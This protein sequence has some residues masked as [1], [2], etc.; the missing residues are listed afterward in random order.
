VRRKVRD[1]YQNRLD[2][3]FTPEGK[4]PLNQRNRRIISRLDE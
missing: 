4:D 1:F 3:L 2:H